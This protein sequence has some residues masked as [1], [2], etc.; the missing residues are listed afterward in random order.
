MRRCCWPEG[1]GAVG[2]RRS[3]RRIIGETGGTADGQTGRGGRVDARRSVA[4]ERAGWRPVD[5][6]PGEG[7]LPQRGRGGTLDAARL[8]ASGR[9]SDR[10]QGMVSPRQSAERLAR[11]RSP[12][13]GLRQAVSLPA[14]PLTGEWTLWRGASGPGHRSLPHRIGA[15]E[16]RALPLPTLCLEAAVERAR[17]PRFPSLA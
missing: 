3:E 5:R 13:P 14:P 10:S 7:G 1:R 4:A 16:R 9:A 8:P 6:R 2:D 11:P 15:S 12:R 17:R